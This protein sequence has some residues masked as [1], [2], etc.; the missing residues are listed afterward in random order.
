MALKAHT[1][2]AARPTH[3]LPREH[4]KTALA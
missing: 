4:G 3:E 2:P 1:R